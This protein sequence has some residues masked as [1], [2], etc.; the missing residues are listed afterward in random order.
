M[1]LTFPSRPAFTNIA[2]NTCLT[3]LTLILQRSNYSEP[4]EEVVLRV[5]GYLMDA[6]LPPIRQT[7][8]VCKVLSALIRANPAEQAYL[9]T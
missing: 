8:Y 4:M 3:R 6:R 9:A 7:E 5:Q 2:E 1:V